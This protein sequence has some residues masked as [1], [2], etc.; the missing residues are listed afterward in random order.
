MVVVSEPTIA[1]VNENVC[2]VGPPATNQRTKGLKVRC[3]PV[4]LRPTDVPG[5]YGMETETDAEGE[6]AATSVGI[7]PMVKF[8]AIKQRLKMRTSRKTKTTRM[9]TWRKVAEIPVELRPAVQS[10]VL[11]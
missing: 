8:S 11:T 4:K 5:M 10:C 6:P 3:G 2:V 1:G 9:Q 7:A